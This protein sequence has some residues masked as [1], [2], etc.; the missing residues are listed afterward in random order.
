MNNRGANKCGHCGLFLSW[1]DSDQYTNFGSMLDCEP[2][3]AVLICKK[4]AKF[5]EDKM[6]SEGRMW[7]PW[8][9]ADFHRRAAKRLGWKYAR[10]R[11]AAWGEYRDPAKPLPEGWEWEKSR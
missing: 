3:D 11:S 4:C 5:E 8:I 9:P 10:P 1:G 6:V 7:T 2:P